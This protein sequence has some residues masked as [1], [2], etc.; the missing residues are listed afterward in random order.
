MDASGRI[1]SLSALHAELHELDGNDL[2]GLK[3]LF[4]RIETDLQQLLPE[5]IDLAIDVND[6]RVG[7]KL[8]NSLVLIVNEFIANS[9]KHAFGSGHGSITVDIG[10][11][12]GRLTLVCRDDGTAGVAEAERAATGKGL[13]T[14]IIQSIASTMGVMPQW[15][16]SGIGMELRMAGTIAS[17]AS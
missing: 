10:V 12:S 8:A 14:R 7:P 11:S 1:R 16:A 13:G 3:S 15:K 17:T 9:A 5:G 6:D 4:K 2:I